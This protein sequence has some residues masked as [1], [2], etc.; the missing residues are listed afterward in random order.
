MAY[1]S[2]LCVDFSKEQLTNGTVFVGPPCTSC[3]NKPASQALISDG[4]DDNPIVS[5][6]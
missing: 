3:D 4:R 2:A 6:L 5:A 1:Y